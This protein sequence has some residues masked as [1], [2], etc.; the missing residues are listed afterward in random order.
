MYVIT[1]HGNHLM[2]SIIYMIY[3]MTLSLPTTQLSFIT[4]SI[5][6]HLL[7]NVPLQDRK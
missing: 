6:K 3:I 2:F 7:K 4:I 1:D 5:Q